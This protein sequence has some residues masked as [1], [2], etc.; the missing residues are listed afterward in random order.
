MNWGTLSVD[1]EPEE[2]TQDCLNPLCRNESSTVYC[3]AA[4]G[5][6]HQDLVREEYAQ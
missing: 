5:T 1:D 6:A 2:P 4:C 3:S